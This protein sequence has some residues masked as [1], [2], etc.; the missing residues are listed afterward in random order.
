MS[1]RVELVG[2]GSLGEAG[3]FVGADLGG[4][5]RTEEER[6]D[7]VAAKVGEVPGKFVSM[8]KPARADVMSGGGEGDETDRAR[9]GWQTSV[10]QLG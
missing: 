6:L 5:A 9:E 10:E 2:S 8:V 7:T 4:I 3:V 1:A